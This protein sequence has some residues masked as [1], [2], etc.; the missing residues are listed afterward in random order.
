MKPTQK[1]ESGEWIWPRR[2]LYIYLQINKLLQT[3]PENYMEIVYACTST[4]SK[5]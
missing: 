2:Y 1:N 5:N 3:S 4:N